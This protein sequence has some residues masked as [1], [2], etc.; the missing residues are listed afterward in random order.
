MAIDA[1]KLYRRFRHYHRLSADETAGMCQVAKLANTPEQSKAIAALHMPSII[2]SASG[3]AT[4]GRVLHH[5]KRLAPDPENHI[6]FAGFQAGGTRGAHIVAGEREVKIHGEW[7]PVRA[8]VTQLEGFSAH[9]DADELIAW[10]AA[11]KRPPSQVWIVHGE[12]QA[13]DA[14]RVRIK[15]TFGWSARVPEHL[16]TVEVPL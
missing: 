2:I 5:L 14:L 10:M 1:T 3:M 15:E 16:E 4:G 11:I 9:A 7:Y 6:V 12:P 8:S 13:A